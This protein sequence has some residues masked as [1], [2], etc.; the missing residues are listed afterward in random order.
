[1]GREENEKKR[2]RCVSVICC[3]ITNHPKLGGLKQHIIISHCSV[4]QEFRQSSWTME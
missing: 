2:K 4:G 3:Y 1:M